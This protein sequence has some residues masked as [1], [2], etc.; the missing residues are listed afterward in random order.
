MWTL[1]LFPKHTPTIAKHYFHE[2]FVTEG[3]DWGV[4]GEEEAAERQQKKSISVSLRNR[5][6]TAEGLEEGEL[7]PDVSKVKSPG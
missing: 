3:S 1:F 6:K 4:K 7:F 2:T 5:K